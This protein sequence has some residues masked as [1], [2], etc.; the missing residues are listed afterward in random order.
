ME[1]DPVVQSGLSKKDVFALA[2]R[3]ADELGYRPGGDLVAAL[4]K[5]GGTLV[6]RDFWS[7]TGEKDPR[8]GSIEIDGYNDFRVFVANDTAPTRDR[9]TIAHEIGHYVLHYLWH[10]ESTGTAPGPAWASR[11]GNTRVEWEANWFA[12]AFLMP[13]GPFTEAVERGG[14]GIEGAARAFGVS[15]LAARLRAEGLGLT[16]PA[17]GTDS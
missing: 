5:L 4:D 17:S 8:S 14:G 12:A 15:A 11:Y 13:A 1:R 6:Y 9:F 7:S 3:V 10:M 2:E 16:E